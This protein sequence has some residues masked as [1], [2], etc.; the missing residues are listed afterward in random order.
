MSNAY[1]SK[2]LEKGTNSLKDLL[3]KDDSTHKNI[4]SSV[5]APICT[6]C[7]QKILKDPIQAQGS[8]F[9]SECFCCTNCKKKIDKAFRMV[10]GKVYCEFCF[11]N[12][13]K[14]NPKDKKVCGGCNKPIDKGVLFDGQ[15][16]HSECFKCSKCST[17]FE[18][19]SKILVSN[20]KPVCEKCKDVKVVGE[21]QK[22]TKK[23]GD[24]FKVGV[25]DLA[26]FKQMVDLGVMTQK[27]FEDKKKEILAKIK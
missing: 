1:I 17:Q 6:L 15:T 13:P 12:D 16:Y 9:H 5:N 14:L 24:D 23:F 27:E 20:G 4:K 10:S 11:D 25:D 18:K 19:Q 21:P 22:G 8:P 3:D 2:G 26:T 7:H